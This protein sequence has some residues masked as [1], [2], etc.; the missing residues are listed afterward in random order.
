[1]YHALL[2]AA[3]VGA[4][5]ATE[6]G[7]AVKLWQCNGDQAT[8]AFDLSPPSVPRLAHELVVRGT[9]TGAPVKVWSIA[10]APQASS[11]IHI[12]GTGYGANGEELFF[13]SP[14]S[15]ELRSN[16]S[17]LCVQAPA[18]AGLSLFVAP[19]SAAL[20]AQRFAYNNGTG[21]LTLASDTTLCADAGTP[22]PNCT[23]PG[24]PIAGLPFCNPAAPA[25]ERAADLVSRL[26]VYELATLVSFQNEGVPRFG[27]PPLKYDEAL[28]GIVYGCGPSFFNNVT[29]YNSTGCPTSFPHGTALGSSFNRSLWRMAAAVISDEGRALHN[30]NGYALMTWAPDM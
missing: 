23:A 7:D 18:V 1:M 12:W 4:I 6:V 30:T 16:F 29:G 5:S 14:A 27:L 17:S 9:E 19:C 3:L 20:P 24:S 13:F 2:T 26:S 22:L 28:H 8:Q 21:A 25:A 15:G 10:G 11:T